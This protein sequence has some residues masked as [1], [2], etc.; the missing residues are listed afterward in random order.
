MNDAVD[1]PAGE[2]AYTVYRR[3][4]LALC[5]RDVEGAGRVVEQ[6]LRDWPPQ[7]IYLRLFE[8]ALKLSGTM[9]AEGR[10]GYRDE[11]FITWHTLRFLRTVR[12][13]FVCADP[14]GPLAL[15]TGVGQES[16]LIGLRMVCD[17][18]QH[19]GWRVGWYPSTDRATVRDWTRARAPAAVLFSIG[20]DP[21]IEP[22][23][24]LVA[25]LRRGGYRGL[26]V[27]GGAAVNR[28]PAVVE[29]LGAHFTAINGLDLIRRLRA[30]GRRGRGAEAG[31]GKSNDPEFG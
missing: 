8:P 14:A 1:T 16:H 20:L 6:C 29:H 9:F 11:H 24:R 4:W 23:R 19:D 7:R 28:N 22:A 17:F 3:Y 15:A 5:R 21:G 30:H 26:V 18:L 13:R 12:R 25:E 31:P 27:V 10:I 2:T